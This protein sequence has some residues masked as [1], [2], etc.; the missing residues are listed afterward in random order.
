MPPGC[1]K[2]HTSTE[3]TI[4]NGKKTIVTTKTY[5][6]ADGST[7]RVTETIT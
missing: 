5:E 7:K 2:M 3:T 1:I 6:M 4:K